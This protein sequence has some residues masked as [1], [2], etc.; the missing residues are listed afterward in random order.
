MQVLLRSQQEFLY[1][2]QVDTQRG[3]ISKYILTSTSTGEQK[4][5]EEFLI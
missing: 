1:K 3:G 2:L 4:F 5:L